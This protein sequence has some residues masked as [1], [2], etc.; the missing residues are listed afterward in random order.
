MIWLLM[1]LELWLRGHAA[2]TPPIKRA[3]GAG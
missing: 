1:M 2:H 3:I